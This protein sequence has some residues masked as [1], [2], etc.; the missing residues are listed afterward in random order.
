[1]WGAQ[2]AEIKIT[3]DGNITIYPQIGDYVIYYGKPTDLEY[4]FKKLSIFFKE[5]L[6]LKGWD[7]YEAVNVQYK[8]QIVCD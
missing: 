3:K 4:K 8:D 6:P 2:I 5:I 7:A 1:M